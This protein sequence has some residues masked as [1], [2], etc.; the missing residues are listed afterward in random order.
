MANTTRESGF[1]SSLKQL[2]GTT[3][4][5]AQVRLELVGTEVELEKRR[6]FDGLL[7]GA[8]ALLC[9][10][11]GL[12]LFCGFVILL[13]WEGYRLAAVGI[14]ALLFSGAGTFLALQAKK[15]M[16]NPQTMFSASL[17]ELKQD[18]TGL[19]QKTYHE[20]R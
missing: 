7:W 17:N 5:I 16:R 12:A 2:L 6:I 14:L 3:L 9:L 20:P 11:V 8:L 13:F 18:Q 19:Q 4:E 15:R 1:F 10:S